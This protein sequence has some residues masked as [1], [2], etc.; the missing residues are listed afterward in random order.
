MK[1]IRFELNKNDIDYTR[2][3]EMVL[4]CG[5][6]AKIVNYEDDDQFANTT[7][8]IEANT[9]C[10]IMNSLSANNIRYEIFEVTA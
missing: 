9:G 4:F 2:I 3:L 6:N 7:A 10:D 1:R 5:E 8:I